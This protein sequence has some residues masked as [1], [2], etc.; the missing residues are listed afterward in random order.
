M[1]K[2]PIW[3]KAGLQAKRGKVLGQ[4]KGVLVINAIGF[5]FQLFLGI[6]RI[7]YGP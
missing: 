3:W 6:L 2:L 5:S 7:S 4:G 1:A